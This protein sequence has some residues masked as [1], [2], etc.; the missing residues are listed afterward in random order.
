MWSRRWTT[1]PKGSSA[2]ARGIRCC[3]IEGGCLRSVFNGTN[4]DFLL[5]N[6]DFLLRNVDFLLKNVDLMIK[7]ELERW[8]EAQDDLS[9]AAELQPDHESTAELLAEVLVQ[10]D[11]TT[12]HH[13]NRMANAESRRQTAAATMVSKSHEFCMKND[14]KR[15]ICIENDEFCS[16][17]RAG[18]GTRGGR[19]RRVRK[20]K[21][22][23]S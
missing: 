8:S 20:T 21:S 18:A 16:F 17:S 3:S 15:G 14:Q 1:T 12:I 2:A 6:P 9:S 5:K 19:M 10:T 7:Q 4:P 22:N 11:P 13:E 23:S